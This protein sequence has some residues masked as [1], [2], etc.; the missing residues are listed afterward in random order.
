GPSGG[1]HAGRHAEKRAQEDMR[2]L[3]RELRRAQRW[4][5]EARSPAASRTTSTTS[6]ARS[7]ATGEMAMRNAKEGTRLRRDATAILSTGERGPRARRSHPCPQPQRGGER[8]LVQ[9]EAVVQE[10]LH[11]VA[12]SLLKT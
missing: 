9:G 8:D 10:A 7:W 4:K 3:E 6:W 12:A 1:L 2:E 5:Q 11:Q